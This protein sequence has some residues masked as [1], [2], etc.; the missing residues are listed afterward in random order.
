MILPEKLARVVPAALRSAVTSLRR[1]GDSGCFLGCPSELIG[2]EDVAWFSWHPRRNLRFRPVGK[3][4]EPSCWDP[5][6]VLL[7]NVPD[8]YEG[9][10]SAFPLR[11]PPMLGVW[12]EG[13]LLSPEPPDLTDAELV[14]I[15]LAAYDVTGRR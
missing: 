6:C 14:L 3:R 7:L 12:A 13:S 8:P 9:G 2:S 11:E 15:L 5:G 1:A 10:I 4:K